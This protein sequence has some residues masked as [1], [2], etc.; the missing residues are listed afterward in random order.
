[1]TTRSKTHAVRSTFS[2]LPPDIKDRYQSLT[3][4][5]DLMY[6]NGIPFLVTISWNLKFDMIEVQPNR[7]EGTLIEGLIT[8][9]KVYK[10]HGFIMSLALM[11]G[12]FDTPGVCEAL[13]GQGVALNPTGQDEHIGDIEQYIRTIKERMQSTYNMLPFAHMLP[14]LVIEMVSQS[15]FWLHAFQ[16]H[17]PT[18]NHDRAET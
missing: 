4:C 14:R 15:V 12:E 2:P 16:S 3:L 5:A 18:G 10:Q 13:A 7:K 9:V 6:M 8:T 17:E 1:M 11:D